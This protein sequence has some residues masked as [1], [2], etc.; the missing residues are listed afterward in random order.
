VVE[1]PFGRLQPEGVEAHV[2]PRR[3]EGDV[4]EDLRLAAGEEGRTVHARGDVDLALDR[5][6]LV[7]GATVGALLFHRDRFADRVLLDRVDGG[8]DLGDALSV[9]LAVL[10]RG[11]VMADDLV[12]DLVDRLVALELALGRDRV[13]QGLAVRGADL[14]DQRAV[15]LRLLVLDLLFAGL[16][17]QLLHRRAELLDLAMGDIERVEDLG[18]G[19]AVGAGLDHQ[20]RL[21]GTGDDEVQ[22]ELLLAVLGRVDDEVTL[23]LADADGADMGGNRDRRDRQRRGSAVHRKDVVG[24][25]VVD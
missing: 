10:V 7:L 9:D 24:M 17:L 12:L 16:L 22:F 6:D 8:L 14:V 21:V 13:D 19:D 20:D 1:E 3:P 25:L 18:L 15:D 4:G 5:P 23:E 2:H 11:R